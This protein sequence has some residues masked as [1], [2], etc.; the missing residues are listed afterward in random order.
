MIVK[1]NEAE[2]L[3]LRMI[4][5]EIIKYPMDN[6]GSEDRYLKHFSQITVD[7]LKHIAEVL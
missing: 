1:R 7:L 4:H 5:K 3:F 2:A 6:E